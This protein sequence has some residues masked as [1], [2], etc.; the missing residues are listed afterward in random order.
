MDRKTNQRIR[1]DDWQADTMQ[2]T[3]HD[4]SIMWVYPGDKCDD[5]P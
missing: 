5:K 4:E 1:K 2:D 3:E